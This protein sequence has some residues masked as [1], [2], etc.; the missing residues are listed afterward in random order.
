MSDDFF[1]SKSD[2]TLVSQLAVATEQMKAPLTD[3]NACESFL[4][5]CNEISARLP[6]GFQLRLSIENGGY[7]VELIRPDGSVLHPDNESIIDCIEEAI[8]AS[9]N[10]EL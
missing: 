4:A 2:P 5:Y 9:V 1:D 3:T 7:D 6:Q 8:V 10:S